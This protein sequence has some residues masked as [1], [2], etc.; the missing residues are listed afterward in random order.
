MADTLLLSSPFS[1]SRAH[2]HG[3][4]RDERR[5]G[6]RVVRLEVAAQRA[7]HEAEDDVVHG[8]ADVVLDALDVVEA[9]TG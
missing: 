4:H 9:D 3:A 7:A 5:V 8:A 6:Q 1:S 2:R